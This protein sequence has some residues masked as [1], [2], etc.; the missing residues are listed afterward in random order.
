MGNHKIVSLLFADDVALVSS[1]QDYQEVAEVGVS[2]SKS[3][4][5]VLYQKTLVCLL[6]IGGE[7]LPQVEEFKYLRVLSLGRLVQRL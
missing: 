7:I 1:S 4:T 2:T 6:Q 5:M 3:K